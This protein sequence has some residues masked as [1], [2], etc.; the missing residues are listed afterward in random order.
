MIKLNKVKYHK[1]GQMSMKCDFSWIFTLFFL[2]GKEFCKLV[3]H[4]LPHSAT[5]SVMI[6]LNLLIEVNF[7]IGHL[8]YNVI[9]IEI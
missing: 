4:S 2:S 8:L 1:S 9:F 7:L 3:S 6:E 5:M